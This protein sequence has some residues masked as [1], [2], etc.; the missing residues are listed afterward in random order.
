MSTTNKIKPV[1]RTFYAPIKKLLD[2]MGFKVVQE[3]GLSPEGV[4]F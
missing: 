1:E 2:D 4:Y 3:I